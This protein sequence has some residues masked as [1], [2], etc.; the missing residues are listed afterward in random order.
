MLQPSQTNDEVLGKLF[1]IAGSKLFI[2]S[3]ELRALTLWAA[4]NGRGTAPATEV[5][6][7][8]APHGLFGSR[9]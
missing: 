7:P 2:A 1:I 4:W 3:Q 8:S 9:G 6:R 5:V